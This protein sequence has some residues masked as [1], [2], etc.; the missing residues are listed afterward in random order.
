MPRYDNAPIGNTC[1][2]IDE[3]LSL[4]DISWDLDNEDESDCAKNLTKA[5]ELIEQVRGANSTLREWGN[6]MCKERDDFEN[7]VDAL[8][9]RIAEM[10]R[11]YNSE[12]ASLEQQIEELK[13][14]QEC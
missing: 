1:P 8:T 10:E 9:R 2:I 5:M 6:E 13:S 14:E 3:A 12:I 7:E 11:D 4:M